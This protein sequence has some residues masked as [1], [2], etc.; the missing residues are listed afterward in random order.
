MAAM[1]DQHRQ[2]RLSGRLLQGTMWIYKQDKEVQ[3]TKLT[4]YILIFFGLVL[5]TK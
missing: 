2:T 5:K 1:L 4:F 3:R